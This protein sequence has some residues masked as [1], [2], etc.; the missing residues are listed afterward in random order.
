MISKGEPNGSI[1]TFVDFI[2]S[3]KGNAII[4]ERGMLPIN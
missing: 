4:L 3:E 1:K 2:K